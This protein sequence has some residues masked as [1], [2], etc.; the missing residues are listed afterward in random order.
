MVVRICRQRESRRTARITFPFSFARSTCVV[1]AAPGMS[2][3]PV[4]AVVIGMGMRGGGMM[5]CGHIGLQVRVIGSPEVTPR[6][7]RLHNVPEPVIFS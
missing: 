2:A 1:M 4:V 5:M 3:A 6:S 7:T